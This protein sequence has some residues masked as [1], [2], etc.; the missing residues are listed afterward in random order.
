[1]DYCAILKSF[2]DMLHLEPATEESVKSAEEKLGVSF[3]PEY[4]RYLLVLGTATAGSHEFTGIC[5][6]P[7][8]NV[9]D[10][11][12]KER[13]RYNHE[14][15]SMYVVEQL[16]IDNMVIWQSQDGKV[17]QSMPGSHVVEIASSL[18]EYLGSEVSV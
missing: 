10:V 18:A 6:S 13:Q 5:V 8:L 3:S 12:L 1:M 4:R 15:D 9:V 11:T 16:H 2:P 14:C 17:Y 7:R